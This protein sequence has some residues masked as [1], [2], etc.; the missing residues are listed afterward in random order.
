MYT[1]QPFENAF[2]MFTGESNNIQAADGKLFAGDYDGTMHCY[3]LATGNLLWEYYV[4]N[5]G[6]N[7]P[8]G[9]WVIDGSYSYY[10]IAGGMVIM[11]AN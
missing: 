4:G 7:T 10:D 6:L 3:D 8:Y 11:G 1:T 9:T 5:A 2:A